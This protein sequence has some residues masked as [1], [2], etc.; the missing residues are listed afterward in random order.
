MKRI[1]L[2]PVTLF[3]VLCSWAQTPQAIGYQAIARNTDGTV[4]ADSEVSLRISILEG[5]ADGIPVYVETHSITTNKFG[6]INMQIGKG[7]KTLGDFATINWGGNRYYTKI[8]MDV[9]G[10]TD[11]KEIGISEMLSVPYAIYAEKAN[12]VDLQAGEGISVNGKTISNTSPNENQTLVVTGNELTISNGN[13]VTLPSYVYTA[14]DS[15]RIE[16]NVISNSAPDKAVSITGNEFITVSGTYPDY[17]L[18]LE[19]FSNYNTNLFLGRG[20]GRFTDT[21]GLEVRGWNTFV[22]DSAGASNT[23]AWMNTFVGSWAGKDN[24]TGD[25]NT[26]LGQET[27][28]NNTEGADN[29]FLGQSAGYAN[30]TGTDNIFIGANS[31]GRNKTGNFNVY[32]GSQSGSEGNNNTFVGYQAGNYPTS[33]TANNNVFLGYKA[34]FK[35][36]SPVNNVFL[37]Y[38]SGFANVDGKANVFIGYSAGMNE[39]GSNKLYISNSETA[40]PLI[41]GEFDN[42]RLVVNGMLGI[43]NLL[44][45]KPQ[46]VAPGAAEEGDV[47][48]SL[49]SHSILYY[50]GTDWMAIGATIVPSAPFLKTLSVDSVIFK[51]A[52]VACEILKEGS[53]ALISCGVRI[54]TTSDFSSSIPINFPTPAIGPYTLKLT[55]LQQLTTYYVRAFATNSQGE[56]LGNVMSF[57]T[58]E[59]FS[60]KAGT[61]SDTGYFAH[62]TGPRVISMIKTLVAVDEDVLTTGIGDLGEANGLLTITINPDNSVTCSGLASGVNPVTNTVG[63]DNYYDPVNHVFHLGYEYPGG[64]GVRKITEVLTK[65]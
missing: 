30:T 40:S 4:I 8:E 2:L 10:G 11:Y 34:G 20:A 23:T 6:L 64:S 45:L 15:I 51:S 54:G 19:K 28:S 38:Q 60:S 57:T 5:T 24:T 1:F 56:A 26:F 21:T 50:N 3:L 58:P 22:G 31:G 9:A 62:P 33:L 37:G 27:G 7:A 17:T 55:G 63:A 36:K 49:Q 43:D 52:Y 32:V 35:A 48:Y 47:Y 41:Y 12:Q 61:Y 14:G 53:S 59:A 16:N 44:N 13:S 39:L 46:S 18:G 25:W 65:Q 42:C 29:T